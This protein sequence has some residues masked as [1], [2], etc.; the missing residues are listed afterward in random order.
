MMGLTALLVLPACGGGPRAG[1]VSPQ[2]LPRPD[3]AAAC[4]SL[5]YSESGLS[6][7][8]PRIIALDKGGGSGRAFW[9]PASRGD[10]TWRAFYAG[11][12]WQRRGRGHVVVTFRHESVRAGLDLAQQESAVVGRATLS[13]DG[14]ERE[15][16]LQAQHV[17]CPA[18]PAS[19]ESR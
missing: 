9:F 4:Y 14:A 15:T 3:R 6:A 19:A 10:T 8:L 1:V 5:T 2:A 16:T 18:P 7:R 12:R 17:S 13:A 11:G